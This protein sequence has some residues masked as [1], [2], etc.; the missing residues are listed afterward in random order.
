VTPAQLPEAAA[1]VAV[2]STGIRSLLFD[3]QIRVTDDGREDYL[4]TVW[5][6]ETT[7][8]VQ[9]ASEIQISFDPSFQ[10][11]VIH[12]VR[13]VRGA[14]T[15]WSCAPLDVRVI[16][17]ERDLEQRLYNGDLTAI[18]FPKGLR[19]GDAVDYAYSLQGRNPVL[20]GRFDTVLRIGYSYPVDLVRR[21]LVWQRAGALRVQARGGAPEPSVTTAPGE[22][23]YTWEARGARTPPPEDATPS[24]FQR[25]ARVELSEFGDWG[26]VARRF[27]ELF[28]SVDAPAP[29]L[30]ALVRSFG[31]AGASEDARI[32][33]AVRFVQ[34]EVRYLGIEIGPNSHQP[35]PPAETLERRF[36][37]CKDK[38]SLLVALLRRL[39]VPAWP[40]LVAT[41]T[42]QMLDERL[43]SL[44]AFDHAIV[45]LRIG[46]RLQF[47]DATVSEQGGHVRDR[48]PPPFARAL[49]LD[50]A[51]R[52]LTPIPEPLA[53]APT[54]DVEETFTLASW[55]SPARLEVVST[56]RGRDADEM[57]QSQARST[58]SETGKRYRDFYAQEHPD[59]RELAPPQVED[60]RERNVLVVREEYEIPSLWNEGGHDFRAW[61]IRERL[62]RPRTLERVT[63]LAIVHPEHV[64]HTLAVRLPGPPDLETLRETVKGAAFQLEAAWS[65]RGNEA[66]LVYSYRSLRGSLAAQDV[67]RHVETLDR[68]A[69]LVTCRVGA[70]RVAG[71]VA[72]GR[73]DP[74][75]EWVSLGVVGCGLAALAAWGARAGTRGWR[76]RQ[77][78]LAFQART[79]ARPGE[80]P[81]SAISVAT[82][83]EV[84]REG[85]GGACG[86]GGPWQELERT[87][88]VYDRSPMTVVMRRCARCA[89]EKTLYFRVG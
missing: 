24:W 43:P 55:S 41:T 38:S 12:H 33:R 68:A 70:R 29:S 7:A 50:D 49:V 9:D 84:A 3:H 17:A 30:D 56:Y 42:R 64:K 73:A 45:A 54:T 18:V 20:A 76:A 48:Q 82:A 15:V 62:E 32:D 77:R 13:V 23:V 28:A 39:G 74:F 52:G 88:L 27:R 60:D 6:A 59:I 11:L 71:P 25:H 86:C 78:R 26:E 69:D 89:E 47:V 63:P 57:R 87:S 75:D 65:A 67:A 36:G 2:E 40:A 51:A 79:G 21:R 8:G 35:H 4:R 14:R 80:E 16:E 10:R 83:E 5:R 53:E 44:F 46:G 58:R 61:G 19:V 37:D 66:R 31:L 81:Q 22:T 34:D 1:E 72:S 85:V